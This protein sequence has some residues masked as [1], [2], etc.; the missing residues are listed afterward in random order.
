MLLDRGLINA[1]ALDRVRRLEA[2]SG[3]RIDRI[4]AK[5]GLVPER[6][7][8]ETYA[9]LLQSPLVG[10]AEFP[11]E[12]VASDRLKAAFLRH[13]RAIPLAETAEVL[14]LA[15]ADPLDDDAVQAVTFALEK[16]V[17]RRAAAPADVEAAHERLYGAERSL[18]ARI[19]ADVDERDDE[20]RD[21]DLSRLRDLASEAPVIRLVNALIARAVE[22]RAS[23]IHIEAGDG[24][25]RVRYRIDGLLHDIE[26]PPLRLRNAI[27]SRIKIMA[28]LNIAERRL[29]Q[30]GRI[31]HAIR[32]KEIDFRVSVVPTIH[33][34]SVVLRI[35][36][37]GSLALSFE[38]LGFDEDLLASWR[39]VISRPDGIVLVTGPT[40]SG[41]T[42]TLYASLAEL[43][44]P[45]RKILTVE[46]PVEY[47]I[48]GISQVQVVPEI[49]LTFASALRSFLRHNPNIMMIGEIRDLETAQIA[50]QMSLS[51]HLVLSTLHTNDAASTMNRLLDLGIE[52]YLVTSTVRGVLAQRLVRTL[53]RKC[54]EKYLLSEELAQRLGLR[55]LRPEGEIHLYRPVGCPECSLT[56]YHGRTMILELLVVTD[57]V[58]HLVLRRAQAGEIQLAATAEGLRTMQAHGMS[59]VLAG[60]TTPEEVTRAIR[61]G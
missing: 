41:K 37:R 32:G 51:G 36:D 2:E 26:P 45:S 18:I 24:S 55:L 29:P 43:N 30:D 59:K 54:R 28:R 38:A 16:P 52:D 21:S 25:L 20:D 14:V 39:S 5:L 9:A 33:G 27:V 48:E 31:R 15:M 47:I 60:I 4:V 22:R 6:A 13:A 3:E 19:S 58:R 61:D 34:E 46:E 49:G 11:A 42:T 57:A 35:L 44:D 56:G 7:L 10:P 53:C 1:P 17:Q 40:G 50:I 23:D 12:P 8:A